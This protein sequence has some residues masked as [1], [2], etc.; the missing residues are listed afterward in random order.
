[1]QALNFASQFGARSGQSEL[2]ARSSHTRGREFWPA[3][4]TKKRIKVSIE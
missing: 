1:L 3:V 2:C 4:G